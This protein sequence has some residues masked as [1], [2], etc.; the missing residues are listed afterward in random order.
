[1]TREEI[2]QAA[3]E[4]ASTQ[5]GNEHDEYFSVDINILE[6]FKAGAEWMQKQLNNQRKMIE[7]EYIK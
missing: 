6:A 3:K 2:I 4:Y 7:D 5:L 1:M